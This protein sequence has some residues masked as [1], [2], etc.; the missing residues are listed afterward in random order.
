MCKH[1]MMV[2]VYSIMVRR[3]FEI[4]KMRLREYNSELQIFSFKLNG[5]SQTHAT[6][7]HLLLALNSYPWA[8]VGT[9]STLRVHKL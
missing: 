7:F 3:D 1:V 4:I 2:T 6:G 8:K 9:T 5:L